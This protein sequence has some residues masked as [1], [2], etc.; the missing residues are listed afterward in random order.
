MGGGS[1]LC[2]RD[3]GVHE[4]EGEGHGEGLEGGGEGEGAGDCGGVQ[5]GD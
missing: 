1:V 3:E 2:Y 5:E 4:A